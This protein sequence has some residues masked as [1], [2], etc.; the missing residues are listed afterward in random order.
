MIGSGSAGIWTRGDG[1]SLVTGVRGV[2]PNGALFIP[3]P[4]GAPPLLADW[5]GAGTLAAAVAL[6]GTGSRRK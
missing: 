2:K 3:D 4:D 6:A 5:M 1:G